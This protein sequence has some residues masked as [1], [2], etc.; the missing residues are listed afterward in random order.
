MKGHRKKRLNL[1]ISKELYDFAKKWSYVTQVP[2]SRILEE[3]LRAQQKEVKEISP[4]QWLSNNRMSSSTGRED[5]AIHDLEEY[6]TNREEE[7]FCR[8]NPAHPRAKIR[9]KLEREYNSSIARTMEKRKR[10]EQEFIRRWIEVFPP[11]KSP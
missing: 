3:T 2:V 4:F 8:N 11:D 10:E 1:Y 5:E 9:R 6:L 7:E